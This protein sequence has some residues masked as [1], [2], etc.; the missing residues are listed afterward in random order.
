MPS[1]FCS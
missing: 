1:D